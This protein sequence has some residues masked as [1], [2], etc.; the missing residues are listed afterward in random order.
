METID[1][2]LAAKVLERLT[3]IEDLTKIPDRQLQGLLTKLDMKTLATA[4]KN[5]PEAVQAKISANLS[6]RARQ[7]LQEEIEFLGDVP[8][9]RIQEAQAKIL[10]VV[11]KAEEAGEIVLED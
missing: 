7:V 1:P 3:R 9:S 8:R 6:S 10:A 2:D 4:L 5:A 11:V